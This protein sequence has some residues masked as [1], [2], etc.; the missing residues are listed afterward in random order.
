MS[1]RIE[2][3]K[4]D[5]ASARQYLESVL[6]AV[7]DRWDVQ[8]YSDGAGWTVRELLI[9]LADADRGN[10]RQVMKYA[11]GEDVI[12]ADFD[13]DRYNRRAV[14]KRA[15][16]TPDEARQS[17]AGT[18][19]ELVA[20]LDTADE[21]MLDKEGRHA[22]LRIVSVSELLDI[23]TAHERGHANDIAVVLGVAG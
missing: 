2:K 20:W 3:H 23:M 6:D 1:T 19:A 21:A 16:M 18:R 5:L 12:P 17:L 14:E 9:H 13:L 11:V 8:V 4:A 22:T 10:N 7:G 15:E